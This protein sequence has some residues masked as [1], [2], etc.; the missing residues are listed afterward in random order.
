VSAHLGAGAHEVGVLSIRSS[1][2]MRPYLV[3]LPD[4]D[5]SSAADTAKRQRRSASFSASVARSVE[6]AR[7][8]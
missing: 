7:H 2:L 6:L 4:L 8:R 5:E 3:V 1:R